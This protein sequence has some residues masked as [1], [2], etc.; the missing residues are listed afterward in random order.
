MDTFKEGLKEGFEGEKS[1]K[2]KVTLWII[3]VYTS[4]GWIYL[5]VPIINMHSASVMDN[6]YLDFPHLQY[7][8][9][10]VIGKCKFKYFRYPYILTYLHIY[11]YS[12]C[13]SNLP[14]FM[15]S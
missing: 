11:V 1:P 14:L 6:A 5:W 10:L 4:V 8:E 2:D 15:K 13:K 12:L 7:F 3:L 9:I